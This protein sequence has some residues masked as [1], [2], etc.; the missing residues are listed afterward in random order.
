LSG[1]YNVLANYFYRLPRIEGKNEGVQEESSEVESKFHSILDGQ[2]LAECFTHFPFDYNSAPFDSFVNFPADNIR[3]P[4]D[5]KWIQQ[6][7][8]EDEQLNH[9]H[10]SNPNQYVTKFIDDL[11]MICY[12]KDLLVPE[13]EWRICIPSVLLDG[14]IR[15]NH[16]YW[17]IVERHDCTIPSA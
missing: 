13:N 4:M 15:W 3:N 12:R 11:P 7:Q 5:L 14:M 10:K 1:K 6:H 2:D 9:T 17:A 16:V 8:F